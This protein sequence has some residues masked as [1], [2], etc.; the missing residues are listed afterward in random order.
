M[1]RV[2]ELAHVKAAS[3]PPVAAASV[4]VAWHG[5]KI[6]SNKEEAL[7]KFLER[8][9]RAGDQRAMAQIRATRASGGGSGGF[10]D[11]S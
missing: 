7:R 6:S 5:G 11:G 2:A 1:Q 10:G 8:K 4:R 9:A 3:A